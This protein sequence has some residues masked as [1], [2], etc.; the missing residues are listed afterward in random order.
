ML[1]RLWC[2]PRASALIQQCLAWEPPYAA[3]AGLKRP[4]KK[5]GGVENGFKASRVKGKW[6][7]AIIHLK[8]IAE[9][10]CKIILS[11][12]LNLLKTD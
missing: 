12:I 2:R 4:K 7:G 5:K 10:L 11:W 9:G 8:N 3:G 6:V 1:L